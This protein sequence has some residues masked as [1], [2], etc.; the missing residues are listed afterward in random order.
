MSQEMGLAKNYKEFFFN[1]CS[2]E[3]IF[4]LLVNLI[5][6]NFARKIE[7]TT[8]YENIHDTIVTDIEVSSAGEIGNIEGSIHASGDL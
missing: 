3:E 4:L 1:V 8:L 5:P 7:L 6:G 2:P